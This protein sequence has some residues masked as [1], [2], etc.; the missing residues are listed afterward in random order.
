V[1]ISSVCPDGDEEKVIISSVC[2]DAGLEVIPQGLLRA[3][4]GAQV[5]AS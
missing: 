3:I 4:T 1:I 5:S 2:P